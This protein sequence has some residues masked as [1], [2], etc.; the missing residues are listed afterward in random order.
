MSEKQ[1]KPE[2]EPSTDEL[3]MEQGFQRALRKALNTLP[4]RRI[5]KHKRK[6]RKEPPFIL[7]V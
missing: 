4:E 7:N 1:P 5:A 3:G 6:V 2:L